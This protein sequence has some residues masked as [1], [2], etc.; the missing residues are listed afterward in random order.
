ML[1]HFRYC[2][3]LSWLLFFSVNNTHAQTSLAVLKKSFKTP[4]ASARPGVYWYFMDGNMSEPAITA[5]LESMK[6]AGIG[7]VVFLEVNV[8]VP[9]GPIDFFS[10]Q[11]Q[12]MFVYA[13]REAERLGI[14]VILGIG[15][16][17]AGSGS[18][19]IKPEESMQHLVAAELKVKGPGQHS[20]KLEIAKPVRPYFGV[21]TLT[22]ALKQQWTLFYKDVAVLAFP[23]PNS[24]AHINDI[25]KKALYYRQPYSS[26][27]NV[28]AYITSTALY[29]EVLN[30]NYIARQN[31][32][33]LTGKLK[34]DGTLEWD[35]PPGNWTVMRFVSRNNGAVTRP[36]PQPGLGF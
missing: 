21:G 16:G 24:N 19:W 36:A 12:T 25:D 8:G 1:S 22:P 6:K 17:W 5:D 28:P 11:W 30:G 3:L 18:P 14:E 10:E 29:D 2:L 34:A 13:V 26:A 32:I 23:T 35:V 33:D 9:R 15:P 7:S 4:P 20:L 27:K 31:I